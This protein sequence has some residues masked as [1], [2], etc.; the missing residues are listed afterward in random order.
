MQAYSGWGGL[1]V[2]GEYSKRRPG[3]APFRV[4]GL[5]LA[6]VCFVVFRGFHTGQFFEFFRQFCRVPRNTEFFET[7]QF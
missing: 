6:D 2:L 4:Y 7:G 5:V 3:G 1:F